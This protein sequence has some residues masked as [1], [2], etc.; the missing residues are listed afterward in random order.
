MSA[1]AWLPAPEHEL[2]LRAALLD[3]DAAGD[4]WRRWQA[5][6]SDGHLDVGS[7]RLLPLVYRNLSAQGGDHVWLGR[8]KGVYRRSW[9]LNQELFA[10]SAPVVARLDAAGIPTL[11][12]KGA[13]LA[14][15]HYRDAGAR[16]MD[17][18]DVAVPLADAP[19]AIG[20][21][22][23][24]GLEP[25]RPLTG[26]LVGLSHAETFADAGERAIDLHWD[27]LRW[28]GRDEA[29]WDDAVPVDLRG[30]ATRAPSA[31]DQVLLVAAHAAYWNAWIHPV[32][33]VADL[34]VLLR[35]PID[36]PRLER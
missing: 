8:L 16:P 24:A 2:L 3:G 10:R 32:R 15:A 11:L 31:T 29:I 17:D 20:Q 22:R 12:L 9:V 35:S 25:R 18:L 14:L 6:H 7:F 28:A 1:P 13:G 23:A 34:H 27:L 4:A 33:W 36:W 19:A 26:D 21:L 5:A 30:V